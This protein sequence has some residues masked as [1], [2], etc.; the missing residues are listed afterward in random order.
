M[1]ESEF[2]VAE[3]DESDGTLVKHAPAIGIITNIELD[4]PDRY[5]NIEQ[6]IAIFQTFASQ[7]KILIGC[8]DD[9][10]IRQNLQLDISYSLNPR[11]L[12]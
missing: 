3:A 9:E 1:G 11:N 5:Q 6:V 12:R 8:L 2:L 10:I 7:C 4:H